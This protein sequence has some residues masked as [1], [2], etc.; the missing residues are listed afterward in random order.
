MLLDFVRKVS[1][2]TGLRGNPARRALILTRL[3]APCSSL[4]S[5]NPFGPP[6]VALPFG[7]HEED[8]ADAEASGVMPFSALGG[9]TS[10]PSGNF[11]MPIWKLATDKDLEMDV[12]LSAI[13]GWLTYAIVSV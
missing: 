13:N 11:A 4:T 5:A 2:I 9:L 1:P 12:T 6:I 7:A 3:S 10:D 8:E